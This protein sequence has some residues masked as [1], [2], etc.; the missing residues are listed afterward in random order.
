MG[1]LNSDYDNWVRI[2]MFLGW[3]E[4][5]LLPQ[6]AKTTGG[7]SSLDVTPSSREATPSNL[8]VEPSAN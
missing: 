2:F 3:S 1:A 8:K 4:Y 7:P 6:K 5:E